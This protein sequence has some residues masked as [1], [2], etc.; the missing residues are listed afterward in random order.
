MYMHMY[1]HVHVGVYVCVCVCVCGMMGYTLFSRVTIQIRTVW[2][3]E[4][5]ASRPTYT[6][7]RKMVWVKRPKPM[8]ISGAYPGLRGGVHIAIGGAVRRL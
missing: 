6:I 3:K 4:Q 7:E 2:S 5:Q 8:S 1:R